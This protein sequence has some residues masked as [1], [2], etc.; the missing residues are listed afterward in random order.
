MRVFPAVEVTLRVFGVLLRERVD[1][2]LRAL[3]TLVP[4][5][6]RAVLEV[7]QRFI[8]AHREGGASHRQRVTVQQ[9][10][11]VV[12]GAQHPAEHVVHHGHEPEHHEGHADPS[13]VERGEEEHVEIFVALVR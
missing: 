1:P 6:Q 11:V 5:V 12:E 3:S 13:E 9:R 8:R 10:R 2:F 4:V 7:T